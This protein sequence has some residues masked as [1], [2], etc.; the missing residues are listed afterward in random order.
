MKSVT[1]NA[2]IISRQGQTKPSQALS[3]AK[4]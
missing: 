2:G 3:I 1:Y 4:N